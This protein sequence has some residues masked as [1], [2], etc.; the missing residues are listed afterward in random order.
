MKK[1]VTG[2]KGKQP[3]KL[4]AKREAFCRLLASGTN[5][6]TG[7]PI[8]QSDAYRLAFKPKNMKAKSINEKASFLSNLVNIQARIAELMAPAIAKVT[9]TREEWLLEMEKIM[10]GDVRKMFIC[11]GQAVEIHELD[12]NEAAIIEGYKVTENF[13]KVGD[14]AEH[15]GYTHDVKL[16]PKLK[17]GLEFGKLMG[18]Y[19]EKFE[20]EH[21]TM[22]E[23]VL[24]S[25]DEEKPKA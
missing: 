24:G 4:S 13:A 2:P 14:R 18:W 16:T 17:R 15:V 12:D 23:L 20:I 5:P 3:Y 9:M 6:S 7:K 10:R 21:T 8:T 19:K 25:M 22:E 1:G 11:P